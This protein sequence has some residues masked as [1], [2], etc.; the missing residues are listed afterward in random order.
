MDF[1]LSHVP[2]GASDQAADHIAAN[3]LEMACHQ[4][5]QCPWPLTALLVRVHLEIHW[6]GPE[7]T[8]SLPVGREKDCSLFL[9]EV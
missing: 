8:K 3:S 4:Q 9:G 6:R 1:F 5:M 7:T 2:Q